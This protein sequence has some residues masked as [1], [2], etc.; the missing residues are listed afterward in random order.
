[1]LC[2]Y[3]RDNKKWLVSHIEMRSLKNSCKVKWS[4]LI[5]A[6]SGK[7]ASAVLSGLLFPD[8]PA[9]SISSSAWHMANLLRPIK[10]NVHLYT[11]C[12]NDKVCTLYTYTELDP[13]SLSVK[14]GASLVLS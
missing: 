14:P 11:V 2:I 9:K 3:V 10:V 6:P 8:F 7:F 12:S 4:L 13:E 5:R 1:M